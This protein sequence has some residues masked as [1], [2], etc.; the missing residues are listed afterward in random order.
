LLNTDWVIEG[1][2]IVGNAGGVLAEA[3]PQHGHPGY[4]E[5]T[6]P[7]LAALILQPEGQ[8]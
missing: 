2:S 4:L 6:L 7:P 1:G 5:L 3:G 8:G